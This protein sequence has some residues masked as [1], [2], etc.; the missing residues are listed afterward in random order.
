MYLRPA[1]IPHPHAQQPHSPHIVQLITQLYV[2]HL[3][4]FLFQKPT[5]QVRYDV[6][7]DNP[8]IS[9][10]EDSIYEIKDGIYENSDN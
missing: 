9:A 8:A 10:G 2:N 3:S 5:N 6:G 4:P 1:P 7:S